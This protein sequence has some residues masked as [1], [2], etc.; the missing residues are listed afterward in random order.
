M[1]LHPQGVIEG[2]HLRD[3]TSLG[4][5]SDASSPL[6]GPK[7]AR[8]LALGKTFTAQRRS[9]QVGQGGQAI[10]RWARLASTY[11][12]MCRA[13]TRAN[14]HMADQLR[15]RVGLFDRAQQ[16]LHGG[17]IMTYAVVEA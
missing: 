10:G 9:Q 11:S 16:L 4:T 14:G 2:R 1:G 17:I 6:D 3:D 7:Q 8:E 5:P 12:T 15:E 13:R